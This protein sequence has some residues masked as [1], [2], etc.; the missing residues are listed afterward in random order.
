MVEHSTML[1]HSIMT[2]IS[3]EYV[4]HKDREIAEKDLEI[5]TQSWRIKQVQEEMKV[6]ARIILSKLLA[7]KQKCSTF[8]SFYPM[9][10]FLL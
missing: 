9:K 5:S 3:N 1:M 2:Q 7:P 6:I 8:F 4:T 10:A